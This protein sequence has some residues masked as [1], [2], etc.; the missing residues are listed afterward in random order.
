MAAAAIVP[1][2]A[3]GGWI[4]SQ[5]VEVHVFAWLV[6]SLLGVA[7]SWSTTALWQRAAAPSRFAVGLGV[8]AALLGT[9]FGFRLYPHGPHDPLH[10]FHEIGFP[11]LCAVV[12]AVLWPLV[13][14]PPKRPQPIVD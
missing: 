6:P 7:G 2:A 12:T 13:L 1:V 5:Y 14:G 4:Y 10:P 8:F 9:A 3:L 11:Y